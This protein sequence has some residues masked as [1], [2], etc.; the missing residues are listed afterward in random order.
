MFKF[1]KCPKVTHPLFSNLKIHIKK[2]VIGSSKPCFLSIHLKG[3]PHIYFPKMSGNHA[4]SHRSICA[5]IDLHHLFKH[6]LCKNQVQIQKFHANR[7]SGSGDIAISLF[8]PDLVQNFY[9][10][11]L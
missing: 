7:T 11:C 3:F 4:P 1:K 8:L 2:F 10:R 9:T 5:H 6:D